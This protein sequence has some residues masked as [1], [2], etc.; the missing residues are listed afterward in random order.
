MKIV[1]VDNLGRE[2]VSD[3]L[4]AENVPTSYSETI[5]EALNLKH[6]GPLSY[7]YFKAVD[8]DYKLYQFQP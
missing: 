3:V 7:N 5:A 4:V 8:D 1:K 6:G 2:T